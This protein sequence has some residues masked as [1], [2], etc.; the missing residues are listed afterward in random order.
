[1]LACCAWILV[2]LGVC[3]D[4]DCARAR[5][6]VVLCVGADDDDDID[7]IFK[8]WSDLR[9][10]PLRHHNLTKSGGCLVGR[11]TGA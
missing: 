8:Q 9:S 10:G 6:R 4:T 11:I 3:L 5:V 7:E 1:M 2:L